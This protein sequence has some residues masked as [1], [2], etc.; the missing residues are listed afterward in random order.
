MENKHP[1]PLIVV[2]GLFNNT[3]MN[4]QKYRKHIKYPTRDR[5]TLDCCYTALKDPYHTVTRHALGLSDYNL[6]HLIPTNRQKLRTSMR[7]VWTVS[8]WTEQLK[9]MLQGYFA[10]GLKEQGL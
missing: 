9:Q 1:G 3:P 4:F 2:L 10:S 6:L 7:V 8:K 5:N